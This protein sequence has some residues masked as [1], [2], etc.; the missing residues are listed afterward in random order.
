VRP[1]TVWITEDFDDREFGYLTGLFS[2]HWQ[3]PDDEHELGPQLAPVEEALAWARERAD[4]V[5]IR[6][7]ESDYYSAGARQPEGRELPEWP[8]GAQF[9]RRRAPSAAYLD[10]T[11]D[12][13]PILW[14]IRLHVSIPVQK[15]GE[16]PA[17]FSRAV[18]ADGRVVDP[19]P[20][21]DPEVESS[22]GTDYSHLAAETPV[23]NARFKLGA[24]TWQEAQEIAGDI[25]VVAFR[26]ALPTLDGTSTGWT[27]S[28]G[29]LP[30]DEG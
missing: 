12:D 30:A 2:A 3:G 20:Y 7:G 27:F 8:A 11:E 25:A 21:V 23:V 1:G 13:E 10:R 22:G 24:R 18:A 26:A 14:Q 28:I 5:L 17:A 15:L 4:V 29:A 19:A 6:S 9:T 16:F